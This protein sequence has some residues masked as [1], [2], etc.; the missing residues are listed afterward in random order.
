VSQI[1]HG[2]G[3][4]ATRSTHEQFLDLLCADE[5]LLRAEF[6]A[7][8][9]AGWGEQ[10]PPAEPPGGPAAQR[11]P[12]AHAAEAQPPRRVG[13]AG[14]GIGG[15][16]RQ[17]SPPASPQGARP[18]NERQV[19]P[20]RE[21]RS[22]GGRF[23]RPPVQPRSVRRTQRDAG[24]RTA[25]T[26][27]GRQNSHLIPWSRSPRAA[28]TFTIQTPPRTSSS[29]R[30]SRETDQ[31]AGGAGDHRAVVSTWATGPQVRLH[32]I[33][34]EGETSTVPPRRCGAP[35][36]P[37]RGRP[38]PR[39]VLLLPRGMQVVAVQRLPSWRALTNGTRV[40]VAL[41][42]EQGKRQHRSIKARPSC[43]ARLLDLAAGDNSAAFRGRPRLPGTQRFESSVALRRRG[44]VRCMS[45]C[46]SLCDT[47]VRGGI[48][49]QALV[50]AVLRW[51]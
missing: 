30:R 43:A 4:D 19:M 33:L 35:H 40:G 31:H 28:G 5:G 2:N 41:A 1:L 47:H 20:K 7:I 22:R 38:V 12:R 10:P 48:N 15:R 50:E 37:G 49:T 44:C 32:R 51:R 23:A 36:L 9:A 46:I 24:A 27:A 21:S 42:Y 13:R 26:D 11:R 3:V 45:R 14:A 6:D 34:R 8:I 18:H 25:H 39:R 17:R 29:C 16:T